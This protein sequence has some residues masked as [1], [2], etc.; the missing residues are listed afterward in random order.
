MKSHPILSFIA[1]ALGGGV[2]G[3]IISLMIR[4]VSVRA[5]AATAPVAG[6]TR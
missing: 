1:G 2:V 4:P 3:A 5:T 6:T